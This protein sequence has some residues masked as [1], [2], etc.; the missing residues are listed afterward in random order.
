MYKINAYALIGEA[1]HNHINLL[2]LPFALYCQWKKESLKWYIR[3]TWSPSKRSLY[4]HCS[5][6]LSLATNV[7]SKSFN[8]SPFTSKNL[9]QPRSTCCAP[10]LLISDAV[11][12]FLTFLRGPLVTKLFS[13]VAQLCM[14]LLGSP[15]VRTNNNL[16]KSAALLHKKAFI[17]T[18]YPWG[19]SWHPFREV[20]KVAAVSL[21]VVVVVHTWTPG[22]LPWFP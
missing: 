17:T 14:Y 22:V 10:Y 16:H 15:L 1:K 18:D 20:R 8:Y 3:S 13:K 9:T 19:E 12:E 2:Y 7:N 21:V 6:Q 5:T 11:K 4:Y